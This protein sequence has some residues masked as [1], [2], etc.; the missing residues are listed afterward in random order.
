MPRNTKVFAPTFS[1]EGVVR[2]DDI[3]KDPRYG[4][5]DP[6]Y[7]MPPGHLPVRSYLAVPVKSRSGEVIGGLFFGHEMPG[8]FRQEHED[9]ISGAAGVAAVAVDNA[10]LFQA[11][12]RELGERRRAEALLQEANSNL[13]ERVSQEIAERL[14]AEQALRQSQ[15]MEA[16]GQ[17]TGGVAHDFNN[18][19]QVICGNLQLLSKDIAGNERAEKRLAQ[20]ARGR[21]TWLQA[22]LQLLAFGRR[23][24]LEPK[25]VNIGRFVKGMD[26]ML[27]RALGEEIEIETVVSGGLWNAL[28]DPGQIENAIL[29]LAINARD[30]MN[31]QGKL[32]IEAGNALLD[33]RYALRRTMR[34]GQYVMLAVTDTG[35]GIPP[36]ILEQGV[37]SLLQ[38]QA[39]GQ[40]HWP[41]PVDGVRLR[42]AVR[43]PHQDLQRG[44]C[45]APR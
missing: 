4:K 21:L 39:G 43:R 11:V 16:I 28:V 1:G 2:S 10:R 38:H 20:C 35:S 6:Y 15:K 31:G 34:P 3:T 23:Q 44:R 42:Q 19:L 7:G 37:R 18:L 33:D 9:L 27:R 45:R 12:E 22:G 36:E 29:N 40:G 32:T 30:A 41:G 8:R 14:A 13:E 24:P 5:N 25:V 17:L 26:D